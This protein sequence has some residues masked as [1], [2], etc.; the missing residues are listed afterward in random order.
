M[1]IKIEGRTDPVVTFAEVR[2]SAKDDELGRYR[3]GIEF[4]VL[5]EEDKKVIEGLIGAID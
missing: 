5:K 1:E 2:W 4:L 3:S